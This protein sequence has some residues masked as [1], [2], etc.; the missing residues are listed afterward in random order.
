MTRGQ[1]EGQQALDTE[2]VTP[3]SRINQALAGSLETGR[4]SHA[5]LFTVMDSGLVS[6]DYNAT[7]MASGAMAFAARLNCQAPVDDAA[8]GRCL[9]CRL[10]QEGNH[11][12]VRV[13]SPDG[14]SIKIDQVRGIQHDMS[15]KPRYDKG[16][17]ITVLENAEK[18]TQEAQNS[19]LKLLEEPPKNVVFILVTG[20][21]QGLLPTVRSRCQLIR[22][23]LGGRE[24][25]EDF[26]AVIERLRKAYSYSPLEVLEEA[27]AIEKML[28]TQAKSGKF[29]GE[30]EKALV[31]AACWFRDVL[32]FK[33]TGDIGLAPVSHGESADNI[34]A[35]L[36]GDGELYE[37]H[38]L[39]AII[40]RIEESRKKVRQNANVRLVLEALMFDLRQ[41]VC[42]EG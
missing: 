7:S 10:I 37:V 9:S 17:R 13:V 34:R 27:E 36:S 8:C 15:Y 2:I 41:R 12:D 28:Q 33:V 32:V 24:I 19:F 39:I 30:L 4:V 1:Q 40:E 11:P 3:M 26:S 25:P 6:G 35:A 23:N 31:A 16:F 5:Y 20:N 29:R 22:V 14:L 38:D 18:M 42:S 21:P